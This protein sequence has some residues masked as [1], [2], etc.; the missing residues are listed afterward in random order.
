MVYI[1]NDFDVESKEPFD[2][3]YMNKLYELGYKMGK[4]GVPWLKAPPGIKPPK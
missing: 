3:V 4:E 1:P 2:P